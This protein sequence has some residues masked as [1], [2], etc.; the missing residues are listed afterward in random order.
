MHLCKSM[1]LVM[2]LHFSVTFSMHNFHRN[3]LKSSG[4]STRKEGRLKEWI[5]QSPSPAG[6]AA[7]ISSTALNVN[8]TTLGSDE[9]DSS[10]GVRCEGFESL[11][12]EEADD[13]NAA[14]NSVDAEPSPS[15]LNDPSLWVNFYDDWNP[16]VVKQVS[17]D[18]NGDP[19]DAKLTHPQT[20]S[21][22]ICRASLNPQVTFTA[23]NA[24]VS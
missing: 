5:K 13:E 23:A 6:E 3:K 20:G 9:V 14:Q 18:E 8:N 12:V 16:V 17:K 2:F 24:I 4:G 7:S 10:D 1:S 15:A 19:A 11:E 21:I 22:Y